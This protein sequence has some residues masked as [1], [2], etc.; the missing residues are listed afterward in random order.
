MFLRTLNDE[1]KRLFLTLAKRA[2]DANGIREESEE[3]LLIAYADE[4][5]INVS[6]E[7]ISTEEI[8]AK[9]L[10]I[11]N[12]VEINQMTFELV[13]LLLSDGEYDSDEIIFI[14]ELS[15][16][17]KV[18]KERIE[19]MFDLVGQYSGLIKSINKIMFDV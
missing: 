8:Y 3:N 15:V 2:A 18:P 11:S 1:Q 19:K 6:I 10:R 13:G 4:M 7:D 9:L 14:N 5:G 17:L 16:G 12:P